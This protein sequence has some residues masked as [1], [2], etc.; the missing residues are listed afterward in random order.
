MPRATPSARQRTTEALRRRV[1]VAVAM[2]ACLAQL[3]VALLDVLRGHPLQGSSIFGILVCAALTLVLSRRTIPVQYVDYSV[4]PVVTLGFGVQL[5]LAFEQHS[6]GPRM[7]FVGVFLFIAAFSILPAR[8]AGLY[9]ALLFAVLGVLT[10]DSG[11][12]LTLLAE[13]ALIVVLIA[14]L[15]VFGQRIS[16]ERAEASAMHTLASLD[17]LTLLFNRRAMYPLLESVFAGPE[18]RR[19]AAVLILDLDHFKQVNDMHGHGVGDE[20]LQQFALILQREVQ[21]HGSVC[22]WGGEEF[23]VFL[24]GMTLVAA[25]EMAERLLQAIREAA[26]PVGLKVTASGGVAHASEAHTVAEWLLHADNRLYVA[27][28]DGRNRVQGK[29]YAASTL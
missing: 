1:Y 18:D 24:P 28:R 5:Y 12:D 15:T 2:L 27:K 8:W 7:Y 11:G 4:L 21:A 14:H 22:R 19:Q 10:V 20:V 23:L 26:M 9:S 17:P 13:T 16:A 29:E 3:A 25:S 6:V